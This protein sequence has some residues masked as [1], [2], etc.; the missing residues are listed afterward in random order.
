[1]AEEGEKVL[2]KPKIKKKFDFFGYIERRPLKAVTNGT[3]KTHDTLATKNE[4]FDLTGFSKL[5]K[6]KET[7]GNHDESLAYLPYII[8]SVVKGLK[9]N[10]YA[11]SSVEGEEIIIKKY[12]NIGFA[13]SSPNGLMFPVIKGADSKS[14]SDISNEIYNYAEKAKTGKID[15]MDLKG[16]VFT[17]TTYGDVNESYPKTCILSIGRIE[18]NTAVKGKTQSGKSIRASLTYDPRAIDSTEAA[19]FIN[20]LKALLENPDSL[21][22]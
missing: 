5:I 1:M 22:D 3:E 10:P 19:G 17:I 12:V 21:M 15:S 16:S 14:I 7:A 4:Q 2:E 18:D 11:A 8:K 6:S 9:N 13:I 20:D